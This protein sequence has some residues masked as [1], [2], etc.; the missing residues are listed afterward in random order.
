M[1]KI[2][3]TGGSGFIGTNLVEKCRLNNI[4]I[5]NVDISPPRNKDHTCYWR[6]CD[7]LNKNLFN[8]ICQEFDPT[9]IIH[10]AAVTDLDE[11]GGLAYYEVNTK[12]VDNLISVSSNLRNL[13][14]IIFTSTM[15]VNEVGY[16]PRSHFDYNPSTLYGKSKVIGEQMVFRRSNELP[17]FVIIRPTSIWGPWFASPYRDFFRLLMKRRY[18]NIQKARPLKTYGYVE[19]S[20]DQIIKL[21]FAQSIYTDRKIFYIGDDPP[22][23][24]TDWSI[25][26]ANVANIDSVPS[27]PYGVFVFA[28][29]LGDMLAHF[30]IPFPM[31]S[32]RLRNMT[33]SNVV[34]LKSTVELC[35]EVPFSMATAINRTLQWIKSNVGE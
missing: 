13:K 7:L 35:G 11:T 20:V 29:K 12:G 1:I 25:Q 27:L 30:K 32:F 2:L 18:A 16:R 21:L 10:L 23:N 3:I 28:A 33:T 26:I 6:Y 31:T 15:L 9:Y 8:L 5:L 19:N 4:D 34:D 17:E 14:R 22:I 24:I